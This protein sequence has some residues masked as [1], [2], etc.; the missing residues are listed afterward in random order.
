MPRFICGISR[1]ATLGA[2]EHFFY[3]EC[4]KS[5]LLRTCFKSL[6]L[7]ASMT[8]VYC[9]YCDASSGVFNSVHV[10]TPLRRIH[11]EDLRQRSACCRHDSHHVPVLPVVLPQDVRLWFLLCQTVEPE[12]A[13]HCSDAMRCDAMRLETNCKACPFVMRCDVR[14]LTR[15]LQ[16]KLNVMQCL[17]ACHEFDG[18]IYGKVGPAQGCDPLPFFDVVRNAGYPAERVALIY[19]GDFGLETKRVAEHARYYSGYGIIFFREMIAP[20][21]DFHWI[22]AQVFPRACYADPGWN[23]FFQLWRKRVDCLACD[24]VDRNVREE[25]WDHLWPISRG[26]SWQTGNGLEVLP[27]CWSGLL[28]LAFPMSVEAELKDLCDFFNRQLYQAARHVTF[29]RCVLPRPRCKG[30]IAFR[31]AFGVGPSEPDSRSNPGNQQSRPQSQS[32]ERA[33][34]AWCNAKR[35]IELPK[36]RYPTCWALDL[37]ELSLKQKNATKRATHMPSSCCSLEE[38]VCGA[39]RALR[40]CPGRLSYI[41]QRQLGL[42]HRMPIW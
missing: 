38:A 4:L 22:S 42:I 32:H 12:G 11:E 36:V 41:G 6:D 7:A 15:S 20:P 31:G 3:Q 16:R 33:D 35:P 21:E 40:G 27:P 10:R 2:F 5:S 14:Q 17:T 8:S 19:G 18:V 30:S 39:L 37:I 25:L 9:G 24:D 26:F 13:A 29:G 34:A 23:R 1:P 28:L